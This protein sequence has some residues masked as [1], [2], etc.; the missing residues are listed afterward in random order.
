MKFF[1]TLVLAGCVLTA[2][3]LSAQPKERGV[4]EDFGDAIGDV[5]VPQAGLPFLD[6]PIADLIE[7][8]LIGDMN[9][10]MYEGA[11]EAWAVKAFFVQPFYRSR[12][13]CSLKGHQ[14]TPVQTT[15]P[16]ITPQLSAYDRYETLIPDFN[17]FGADIDQSP[18]QY[19]NV[20]LG[21]SITQL[22]GDFNVYNPGYGIV[23]AGV[24]NSTSEDLAEW[25]DYCASENPE[26]WIGKPHIQSGCADNV[27]A[28]GRFACNPPPGTSGTQVSFDNPNA[29][30][31]SFKYNGYVQ[32]QNRNVYI[33]IGGND[34][35]IGL[36][37]SQME[38]LPVLIPFRHMHV[39][40]Q[41]NKVITYV[42]HQAN[43]RVTLIGY[44]PLPSYYPG[45]E[46]DNPYFN[47]VYSLS[48]LGL[49]HRFDQWFEDTNLGYS[50]V[51]VRFRDLPGGRFVSLSDQLLRNAINDALRGQDLTGQVLW[52]CLSTVQWPGD[53]DLDSGKIDNFC[54]ALKGDQTWLSQRVIELNAVKAAVA[55][56]RQAGMYSLY[57]TFL[58][59]QAASRGCWWC[60]NKAFWNLNPNVTDFEEFVFGNVSPDFPS[61]I[62]RSLND[63]IH[64]NELGYFAYGGSLS[65]IMSQEHAHITQTPFKHN[66]G[67][68]VEP[69]DPSP[70][71][72]CR[73]QGDMFKL[74]NGQCIDT[75]PPP[76]PVSVPVI[77]QNPNSPLTDRPNEAATNPTHEPPLL[78]GLTDTQMLLIALCF[79]TGICSF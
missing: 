71:E 35:N 67:C 40:N 54:L 70:N 15:F 30:D 36:Y 27:G 46:L 8:D 37:K 6:G 77:V 42:Q 14:P 44:P 33:M 12:C 38:T 20:M 23:N 4:V 47:L 65:S 39:A 50:E 32:F 16:P 22:A 75:T 68:F 28:G 58:D 2:S 51:K 24:S 61:G 60:G 66:D 64:P 73:A 26:L 1:T 63:S 56:Q 72:A 79:F 53:I 19:N 3:A 5:G 45:N 59:Y 11:I 34:F 52:D 21:D 18:N 74:I 49:Y 29:L 69:A 9:S 62:T 13:G 10:A 48:A 55:A 17:S 7:Q 57:F 76:P 43:T 25:L 78:P 31:R 41:I